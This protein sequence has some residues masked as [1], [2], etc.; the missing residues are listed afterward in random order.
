MKWKKKYWQASSIPECVIASVILMIVFFMSL[1]ILSRMTLQATRKESV[2]CQLTALQ[3]GLRKFGDG[4][5]AEGTYTFIHDG[6]KVE[7]TLVVYGFHTQKL[8]LS[9]F[10]SQGLICVKRYHIIKIQDEL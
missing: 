5:H 9:V 2:L 6:V 10:S 1:E 4:K 7:A 3:E 8:V